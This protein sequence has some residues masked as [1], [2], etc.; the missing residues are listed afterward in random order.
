MK[1]LMIYGM[2][3]LAFTSCK[4][5]DIPAYSGENSLYFALAVDPPTPN[6]N[7]VRR[8]SATV[9]FGFSFGATDSILRIPVKVTGLPVHAARNYTISATGANGAVEGTHFDFAKKTFTIPADSLSDTIPL[10]LH[11]TADLK[12]KTMMVTITLVPNEN[13]VTKMLSETI[14]GTTQVLSLNT[15]RVFF[16]DI[17]S[18]PETWSEYYVGKFTVKKFYLMGKVL[19][20]DLDRFSG[21]AFSQITFQELNYYGIAMQRYLN[22]MRSEGHTVYEDDGTEMVMGIGVQ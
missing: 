18:E 5:N 22:R 4:K 11:R 6:T 9:S 19:N 3:V 14:S 10:I 15:F 13:F 20:L 7:E 12:T 16:N 21:P 8:D 1:K 2:L 17:L